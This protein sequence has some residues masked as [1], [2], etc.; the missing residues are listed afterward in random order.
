MKRLAIIGLLLL[1]LPVWAQSEDE[2]R[3]VRF[4]E[5]A[6]SDG[7]A[8]SVDLQGF[9]GAL[10]SEAALDRLTVA[11]ADG[12]W[13]E[14]EGAVLNWNRAAVLRGEIEIRA[15]TADRLVLHRLP[16]AEPSPPTPEAQGFALPELPVSIDIQTAAIAR[17]ELGAPVLGDPVQ[18]SAAASLTLSGGEGAAMLELERTDAQ[19]GRIAL[20]A[21]YDNAT[22]QTVIDL[23]A[24]E[25]A[26]GIAVSL[27]AIEDAPSVGLQI[28]GA[29]PLDAFDARFALA[30]DGV[31]RLS[32]NAGIQSDATGDLRVDFALGGDLRPVV[33]GDL[34][35]FLGDAAEVT[36]LARIGADGTIDLQSVEARSA[37]LELSGD[38]TID[39]DGQP[40]QFDLAGR[41]SPPGG[42]ETLALPGGG[43]TIASAT[44]DLSY[45]RR[46]GDRVAGVAELTA[47]RA[48]G[49]SAP[50]TRV[51]LDGALTPGRFDGQVAL[52]SDG[53]AHA[54][55]AIAEALGARIALS[56]DALWQANGTFALDGLSLETARS[57]ADGSLSVSSNETE[58]AV[59]ASLTVESEDLSPF[60]PL[61]GQTL[62]GAARGEVELQYQA[63]SGTFETVFS[64]ETTELSMPDLVPDTLLSGTTTLAGEMRRDATGITLDTL[65]LS[66]TALELNASGILRSRETDLSFEARLEDAARLESR[67]TGPVAIGGR[68]LQAGDR[69]YRLTAVEVTSDMG[70]LTGNATLTPGET[71]FPVAASLNGTVPLAPWSAMVGDA[72]SGDVTVSMTG[73]GDLRAE[74][75][76]LDVSATALDLRAGR[77]PAGLFAGET[78]LSGQVGFAQNTLTLTRLELTGSALSA[79][80]SGRLGP[81]VQQAAL[82]ARLDDGRILSA[83]LPGSITLEASLSQSGGAP[84]AI[85]ARAQG[86]AGLVARITGTATPE[87]ELDLRVQGG[88]PLSLA[89]PFIAPQTLAGRAQVDLALRGPPEL[90]AA[91]GTVTIDGARLGMPVQGIALEDISSRVDIS[92]GTARLDLTGAFNPAGALAVSGQVTLADPSLPAAFDISLD[93]GRIVDP[94]LYDIAIEQLRLALSGALAHSLRLSG[95][96]GL[97]VV[98][99]RVPDSG[100]G[101]AGPVPDIRHIGETAAERQT[102]LY[103]GL[104]DRAGSGGTGPNV[105]LDLGITAPGRI[106]LRGRGLDAELGGTLRIGGTAVAPVAS[107]QF[108]LLRGRLSILG[109][110]LDLTDGRV[111]LQ[112]AEPVLSLTAETDAGEYRIFIT[113]EGAASAPEV[114]FRSVP[115]LPE[116]EVLAQLIFGRSVGSLSAVQALQLADGVAGLAGGGSGVFTRL[117]EQF[118]LD[119]LDIRTDEAGN[120]AVTAGRYIS[121]NVYTDVTVEDGGTGV[122]INIDLTPSLTARGGVDSDG[123]SSLGVFFE[124]DY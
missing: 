104:I 20:N 102:R 79:T 69:T 30:T 82:T 59:D 28:T 13:L 110:R 99:L 89:D 23:T 29:G 95:E 51:V 56:G 35:T 105:A 57:R 21:S 52:E 103:A 80:A 72:L 44:V 1:P 113:V 19:E 66:G 48:A 11:D 68:L 41:L 33:S 7:A 70:T 4:I 61:L 115:D 53:L 5:D 117:R 17:L 24:Q 27:L 94:A 120:A 43:A 100:I 46:Q 122:S 65:E 124:R 15:L 12:I 38:L 96:V 123:T 6:L 92:D 32:G 121:E 55:P 101:S 73:E 75:A 58:V 9:R 76:A 118:G 16:V 3:L 98:E 26:G 78:E 71:T 31:D 64:A 60:G 109:Q 74:T 67:L 77:L 112:G 14:I 49:F 107:G 93:R 81:D 47:L 50:E 88:L 111:T 42:A 114:R 39:P 85:D 25:G 2:G 54:D 36:A 119:D 108:E 8:R 45:D 87:P 22:T 84:Y 63:L 90:R 34:E 97:G 83:A 10:S 106:F 116:D 91:S 86:P 37:A 18:A 40:V 62:G